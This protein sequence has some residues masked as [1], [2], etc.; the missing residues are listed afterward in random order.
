MRS[1]FF[2]RVAFFIS[3]AGLQ[4]Y[5]LSI[6]PILKSVPVPGVWLMIFLPRALV[7]AL[8]RR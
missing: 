8:G 7:S 4:N 6:A 2:G 5:R 1:G 3:I